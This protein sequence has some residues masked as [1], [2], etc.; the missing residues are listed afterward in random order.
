MGATCFASNKMEEGI[1][2]F[3]EAETNIKSKVTSS[4]LFGKR[5]ALI[6]VPSV[7]KVFALLQ[8]IQIII[9]ITKC[10]FF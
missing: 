6:G 7:G 10:V 8:T 9:L 1:V 5:V 4:G 3:K 2:S